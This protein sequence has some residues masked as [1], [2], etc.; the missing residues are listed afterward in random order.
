M[1]APIE[2][3]AALGVRKNLQYLY[4]GYR[5]EYGWM[6]SK[7]KLEKMDAEG[8]LHWNTRGRPN[9]R[10]FL[11]E[12]RGQPIANLWT[13]VHVINPMANE[14]VDYG[15]QKPEKLLN[16]IIRSSCPEGGLAADFNGGS[17]TTAAAAEKLG[18]RW[19]TTDLGKPACMIMRKRLIDQDA[20]PFLYQAI[21]DY[22][23]EA[24]KAMLG[25]DFRIGDLSQIV[26]S[27]NGAL[28]LP[29]DVNPQ[30]N[31]GQIAALN[32]GEPS[33]LPSPR[34]RGS[35]ARKR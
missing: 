25:R 22:Q 31:L 16:R 2:R 7:E 15:T 24:A 34:G 14:H 20:K 18:R 21:G 33:P 12:Y 3:N 5:P 28:P 29:P 1:L 17:G 26:L 10:V 11:D 23:V 6:M 4:K 35:K 30:R 8:K 19:I 9:R 27:L 13:D 32:T